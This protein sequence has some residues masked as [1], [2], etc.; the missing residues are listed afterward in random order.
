M[1]KK[2]IPLFVAVIVFTLCGCT[3]GEE[4][5]ISGTSFN[6]EDYRPANAYEEYQNKLHG[7]IIDYPIEATRQGNFDIDGSIAFVSENSEIEIFKP[8]TENSETMLTAEEYANEF[9]DARKEEN[10]AAVKYGKSSGFRIIRKEDDGRTSVDFVVKG[11]DAFYRFKYISSEPDFSED[12]PEFQYIMGSIRIDDG[13]YNKLYRMSSRYKLQLEYAT[14]MQYITDSNYAIHCLNNY[15]TTKNERNKAE[16]IATYDN[17]KKEMTVI[18]NYKREEGE[19][20]DE[21][22]QAVLEG[23]QEIYSA[24]EKVLSYIN[25]GR[26]EE[27]Q[28]LSRSEFGYALSDAATRF[29]ETINAELAEY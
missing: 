7:I 21:E 25:D 26:D 29:I 10:T 3:G 13:E 5:Y 24:C 20:F 9:L 22:W 17:I 4:D 16:A 28:R 8:D 15:E 11:T 14:S 19:G 1:V 18:I 27:A 12:N 2:M 23:A 6:P